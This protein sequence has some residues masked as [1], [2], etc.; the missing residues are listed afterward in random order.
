MH[1]TYLA[2]RSIWVATEDYPPKLGGL[3]R[4]SE[5][6][7]R[8]LVRLGARVTVLAKKTDPAD[9]GE[10]GWSIVGVRGPEFVRWR[11]F[12]FHR[13]GRQLGR[14]TARPDLIIAST[15][16]VG[17]GFSGRRRLA[18]LT[19]AVHG[20]E[21]CK[22]WPAA[23]RRRMTSTL[24]GAD[25]VVAASR[26]TAGFVR[27]LLPGREV[28]VGLNGFD[29]D[30][31]SS[32]GERR[33][34][35]HEWQLLSAGR[36]VERKRFDLVIE[37]AAAARAGG[38]DVGLWI[39]GRGP[40]ENDLRQLV[41]RHGLDDRVTFLGGRTDRDLADLYR[42]ADL[43]VSP[44]E[45]DPVSGDVEGFGLTFIEAAACGTPA[46]ALAE[47]GVT[48]AVENGVS[49]LLTTRG[50]FVS[51]TVE[52]LT[53]PDRIATLA[54]QAEERARERFEIT[55]VAGNLIPPLLCV[56]PEG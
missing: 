22:P 36:L 53:A 28:A 5:N 52:L 41:S 54:R 38:H 25:R 45:S 15:W 50:E 6:T 27:E 29:G 31:F 10:T 4:W 51:R 1:D 18:P 17:E 26:Y 56:E 47:G 3:A 55:N 2:G 16:H 32:A 23:M 24:T 8:G 11:R 46:T 21:V 44:C 12:H 37:V 30:I 34:K 33:P 39:V 19:I 43:F 48:D 40:L 20:M 13:A 9:R 35:E 7:A 42:S 14:R 49:G